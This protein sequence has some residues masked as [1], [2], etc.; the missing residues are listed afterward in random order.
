MDNPSNLAYGALSSLPPSLPL[1][2][3]ELATPVTL[4]EL[5]KGFYSKSTGEEGWKKG[6]VEAVCEEGEIMFVSRGEEVGEGGREGG[7]KEGRE[8]VG[9][10]G[11]KVCE[12]GSETR[13]EIVFFI[14]E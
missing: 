13:K 1:P 11:R 4:M 8:N 2:G 9:N 7:R 12:N 5:V 10:K 14:Q 3:L 6:M